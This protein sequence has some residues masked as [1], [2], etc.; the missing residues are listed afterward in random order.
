M[1][2]AVSTHR[3]SSSLLTSL[4]AATAIAIG[5]AI[6]GVAQYVANPTQSPLTLFLHHTWHVIAL[7]LAIYV[8]VYAA[9]RRFLLGPLNEIYL[10]LYAVGSGRV[11]P[12]RIRTSVKEVAEV[13][14]GVNL[15]IRRMEQNPNGE[16]RQQ[17]SRVA[18]DLRVL[19][20]EHS[21]ADVTLSARLLRSA[22]ALDRARSGLHG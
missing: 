17:V 3:W 10:H 19:A 7:W 11:R 1:T 6:Y 12:L 5:M 14:E 9:L 16:V 4:V 18:E 2:N 15:M 13:V 8:C 20:H 21:P 22:K